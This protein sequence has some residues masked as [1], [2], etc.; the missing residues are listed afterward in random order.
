MFMLSSKYEKSLWRRLAAPLIAGL[1]FSV[2][3]HATAQAANATYVI[4]D[5]DGYGVL[6]C[7]TQKSDC[8]KIVADAW[9]ES[10]GHGLAKA[11]GRAEDVTAAISPEAPREPLSPGA[12]IVSCSD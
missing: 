2:A 3:Y 6:E 10:H 4:A 5:H 11:F 1:L 7:L 8:G 12:A 9:C